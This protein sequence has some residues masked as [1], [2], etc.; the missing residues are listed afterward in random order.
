[1]T[2][3]RL[4]RSRIDRMIG[5]VAGGL[6]NYFDIDPTIVRVLF[7]ITIFIGGGGILAYIILWI[8]VPEDP[9]LYT[10]GDKKDNTEK[11]N[12]EKSSSTDD[13]QKSNS[14]NEN[15]NNVIRE[16]EQDIHNATKQAKKNIDNVIKKAR[17]N[18][19]V[20][21]GTL[22]IFLGILFL[23]DNLF[24]RFNLGQYWPFILIIVGIAIIL[25]ATKN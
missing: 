6:A 20:F 11:E 14:G 22:L 16:V 21:G 9:V 3:K 13:E 18:K 7:V 4:Y 10:P 15:I 5:G 17:N 2:S 1:M 19:K 23:L 24:P 25:K 8:V 12:A